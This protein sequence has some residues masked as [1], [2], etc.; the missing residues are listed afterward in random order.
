MIPSEDKREFEGFM[1]FVLAY[2]IEGWAKIFMPKNHKI[3]S[4]SSALNALNAPLFQSF[5][6]A[7]T[8]LAARFFEPLVS[9]LPKLTCGRVCPDLTDSDWFAFGVLRVLHEVKTGRAFL[10]P[11]AATLPNCPE[12]SQ[13]FSTLKSARRLRVCKEAQDLLNQSLRDTLPDALAQVP[14]LD[15][16]DIYAGDGHWLGAAMHDARPFPDSPKPACGHFYVLDLRR[17]LL[18][19][20]DMADQTHSEHE[21]DMS[22]LKRQT[23]ETLRQGAPK[24]RKV[25]YVWDRAGI[26]LP[27]WEQWKRRGIYWLTRRKENMVLSIERPLEWEQQDPR[28]AGV[29]SDDICQTATV[30]RVRRIRYLDA[31]SGK[32]YEFIT[33]QMTIP[34]GVIA[35]LARRR[36]QIEKVFDEL[37]NKLEQTGAWASSAEAKKMQAVFIC[38]TQHLLRAMEELLDKEHQIRPER[39]LKRRE[40]RIEQERESV[41]KNG[42]TYPALRAAATSLTQHTVKFLRWLRSRLR[43]SAPWHAL[44]DALRL[45]YAAS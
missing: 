10:D 27:E 26:S 28:N 6:S 16:F 24:G 40:K 44:I 35:E 20:L 14:E 13:F 45:S 36:W 3:L 15:G 25:L 43:E 19:H 33:N 39:E 32:N 12:V 11:V 34:P 1:H 31:V 42:Q 7:D 38:M 18:G 22:A 5:L 2:S 17:R 9:I 8:P 29:L 41:A 21:H 37:K 4:P 23:I 30:G